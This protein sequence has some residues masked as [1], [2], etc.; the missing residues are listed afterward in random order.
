MVLVLAP[1]DT[2]IHNSITNTGVEDSIG[3]IHEKI[4]SEHQYIDRMTDI[5]QLPKEIAPSQIR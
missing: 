3:E 5:N 4:A 1:A 2:E